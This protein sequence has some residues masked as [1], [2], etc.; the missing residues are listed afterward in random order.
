MRYLKQLYDKNLLSRFVVD[1]A[2]CLNQWGSS[3][4]PD[5]LRLGNIL[6]KFRQQQHKKVP[7]LALTASASEE[8]CNKAIESLKMDKLCTKALS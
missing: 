2:H 3:F 6:Q 7:I 5:F 1:E 4:R 8:D